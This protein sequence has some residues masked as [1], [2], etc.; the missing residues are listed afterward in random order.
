MCT[1]WDEYQIFL[2]SLNNEGLILGGYDGN[3]T[4]IFMSPPE[5]I[6]VISGQEIKPQKLY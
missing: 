6:L 3:S 4:I 2:V 1:D 5:D